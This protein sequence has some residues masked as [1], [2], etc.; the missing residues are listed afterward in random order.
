MMR[1]GNPFRVAVYYLRSLRLRVVFAMLGIVLGVAM[2]VVL[3]SLGFGIESTF[4]SNLAS[5]Y[6]YLTVV[7]SPPY[8]PGG[9]ASTPGLLY[10]KDLDA[11]RGNVDPTVVRD[12][13]PIVAGYAQSRNGA[14]NFNVYVVGST[15]GYLRYANIKIV[16]GRS[17][18]DQEYASAARV[19]VLG[20]VVAQKFYGTNMA[21]VGRTIEMGRHAFVVIGVSRN[22]STDVSAIMPL[23]TARTALFG[24]LITVQQIVVRLGA[25]GEV[26]P[27]VVEVGT[28]LDKRHHI[29]SPD[30]R[31]YTFSSPNFI[32]PNFPQLFLIFRW[33]IVAV[34]S[35]FLLV[36]ML[37]LANVLSYVA[38]RRV[39]T[40]H[41]NHKVHGSRLS[42]LRRLLIESL[43]LSGVCGI[44]G[45]S[46]GWVLTM[47][48]GSV[49][50]KFLP[51]QVYASTSYFPSYD[52]PQVS[53]ST[54]LISLA[55]S[56]ISGL[57][58]SV[59]SIIRLNRKC[60]INCDRS[61]VSEDRDS[62]RALRST[63]DLE[64][65][66]FGIKFRVSP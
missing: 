50:A 63:S 33:F 47:I 46:L 38:V 60:T 66:Q 4:R 48:G 2:T 39:N 30:Q 8:V 49:M 25:P 57:F 55:L 54:V 65:G 59:F 26:V 12:I 44:A 61:V 45:I 56:L 40:A 64:H 35:V 43:A 42:I 21:A 37:G 6:D 1:V 16:A 34:T 62:S 7:P 20:E 13:V 27:A 41:E 17:F 53:E 24:G 10:D 29:D 22:I 51:Y 18:G 15:E 5:F 31:D 58:A 3:N 52:L 11:L 19:V 14:L 28:I 36:G 23:T 9:R 32:M